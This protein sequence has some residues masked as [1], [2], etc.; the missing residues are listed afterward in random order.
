MTMTSDAK[1]AL[2]KTIRGL[3]QRLIDDLGQAMQGAYLL[4]IADPK[5]AS[6]DEAARARRARLDGWVDE[7]VRA[8]PAKSRAGAAERLRGEI[9]KDAAATRWGPLR[10][11]TV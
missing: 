9:V 5:K 6:L 11:T 4:S 2:A 10:A 1:R 3:R 8:L 7:Q